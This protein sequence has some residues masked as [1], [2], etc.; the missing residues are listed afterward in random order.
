MKQDPSANTAAIL[1]IRR[2]VQLMPSHLFF[3][4]ERPGGSPFPC[5]TGKCFIWFIFLTFNVFIHSHNILLFI[6]P[7]LILFRC[8][9]LFFGFRL[10][11]YPCSADE[12]EKQDEDQYIPGFPHKSLH[13]KRS[14]RD[15]PPLIYILFIIPTVKT[16]VKNTST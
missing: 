6:Y 11:G 16:F 14:W 9:Y 8:L 10:C 12:N 13:K 2:S 7:D 4:R 1:A 3:H 15:I 5:R